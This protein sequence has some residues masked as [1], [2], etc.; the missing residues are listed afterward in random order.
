MRDLNAGLY[1][2]IAL[3]TCDPQGRCSVLTALSYCGRATSILTP[4]AA[5]R[6]SRERGNP[7]LGLVQ[8]W[9]PAF[10]GMTIV[11]FSRST[12]CTNARFEYSPRLTHPTN[13]S[14]P[15]TRR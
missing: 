3:P 2:G 4:G 1:C 9:I 8:T 13:G 15:S 14:R 6:H 5:A 11:E 10:A 7:F 12:E